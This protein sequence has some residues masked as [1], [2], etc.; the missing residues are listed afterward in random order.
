MYLGQH[1]AAARAVWR[2]LLDG[3]TALLCVPP[4]YR[5]LLADISTLTVV[6]CMS[7]YSGQSVLPPSELANAVVIIN[8]GKLAVE[9]DQYAVAELNRGDLF[10][11]REGGRAEGLRLIYAR[12]GNAP[13]WSYVVL[14]K[15]MLS[16][17]PLELARAIHH[18]AK[19]HDGGDKLR[20][21]AHRMSRIS[22]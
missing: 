19:L 21:A 22:A 1:L 3:T 2:R 20:D 15:S 12:G 9:R 8:D 17:L 16:T 5:L 10:S 18:F 14:N 6:P 7:D 4:R 11:L 13:A